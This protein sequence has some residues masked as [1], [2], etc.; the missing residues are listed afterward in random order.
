MLDRD[1]SLPQGRWPR[2]V[3]YPALVVLA[4]AGGVLTAVLIGPQAVADGP[5]RL[6]EHATA[7]VPLWL[8]LALAVPI[9]GYLA[10]RRADQRATHEP[11]D[12]ATGLASPER[13]AQSAA[14]EIQR[15]DE[16]GTP[17]A[18]LVLDIDRL[19]RI[20]ESR[21]EAAGDL[22]LRLVGMAVSLA[23]R[24]GDLAVRHDQDEFVL[25]VPGLNGAGAIPL[26]N[27][28]QQTAE[29]LRR[30]RPELIMPLT[31][32]VGIADLERARGADAASLMTAA[33]KALIFAKAS[34]RHRGGVALAPRTSA[35]AVRTIV[36]HDVLPAQPA[37]AQV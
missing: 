22:A 26:A 4:A 24:A 6:A 19:K 37:M 36:D 33:Q 21:G 15:A 17:V 12:P 28:I 1:V 32:S 2:R 3:V 25:V 14:L 31:L 30:E 13:F 8:G 23:C 16:T 18:L 7:P 34:S 29:R 20:N 9:L 10:G 5:V 27:R 11:T 35:G